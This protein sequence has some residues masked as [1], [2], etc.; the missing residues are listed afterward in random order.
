VDDKDPRTLQGESEKSSPLKFSGIFSPNDM[1][2]LVQILH[3][4][5]MFL[6][7]L[8]YKILFN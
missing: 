2:F 3:A 4:Y 5:Y 6:S 7:T 8:D 1:E